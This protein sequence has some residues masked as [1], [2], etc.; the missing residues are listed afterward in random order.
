MADNGALQE[1]LDAREIEQ[2]FV[3]YFDRV[4]ANDPEGASMCFAE[5]VEFEIMIGKRKHGRER[6]ARS[7]GRVLD[8][9]ERTSHHLSNVSTQIDGDHAEGLAYVYAYHRM[10]NTGEPWHLIARM[11]D[12]FE[13]IDG[14]WQI[15]E[16]VLW[17]LDAVPNRPG[18]PARVVPGPPGAARPRARRDRLIVRAAM[19]NVSLAGRAARSRRR[20]LVGDRPAVAQAAADA[21]RRGVRLQPRPFAGRSAVD[22]ATRSRST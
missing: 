20:R 17:G 22:G 9:Y 7:L 8:Q 4:D 10:R 1:L 12:K 11:K 16:H 13:R 19:A 6:F 2:V 3:R 21:R 15:T 5:D 14:R 18:H